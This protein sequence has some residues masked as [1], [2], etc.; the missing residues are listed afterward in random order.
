[1]AINDARNALFELQSFRGESVHGEFGSS[2]CGGVGSATPVIGFCATGKYMTATTL[3]ITIVLY[4][5]DISSKRE[6]HVRSP[7]VVNMLGGVRIGQDLFRNY[8]QNFG[9]VRQMSI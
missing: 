8:P 6:G 4:T 7:T 1:M 9:I 5:V 3:S 2:P